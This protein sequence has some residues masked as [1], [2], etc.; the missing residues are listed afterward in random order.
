MLTGKGDLPDMTDE[1]DTQEKP[2][3]KMTATEL[4]EVA[5]KIPEIKGAS[6]MKKDELLSAIKKAGGIE[7]EVVTKED[8]TVKGLKGSIKEMKK[9]RAD[10]IES[11]DSKN[12][13]IFKK[14]ISRL[15][16]RTR[17]SA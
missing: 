4:R 13:K 6:G 16:K 5:K 10:A 3:E 17:R 15:K 11:G 2:L 1:K 8:S 12:A 7:E 9:K 14:R